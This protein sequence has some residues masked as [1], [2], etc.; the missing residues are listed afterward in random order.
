MMWAFPFGLALF[1]AG[2]EALGALPAAH[3]AYVVAIVLAIKI[4]TDKP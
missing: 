3:F 2:A 4:S 1:G